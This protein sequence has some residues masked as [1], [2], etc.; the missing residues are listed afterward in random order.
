MEVRILAV[1]NKIRDAVY[2]KGYNTIRSLGICFK[3]F[4][5]VDGNRK[6][7]K[8]EFSDGIKSFNVTLTKSELD[9]IPY[10]GSYCATGHQQGRYHRLR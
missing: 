7:S 10:L 9:V 4:D 1:M 2:S 8:E 3:H 5:S 6:L